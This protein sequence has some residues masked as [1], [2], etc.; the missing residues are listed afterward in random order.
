MAS[1]ELRPFGCGFFIR[2]FLLGRGPEGSP[3]IDPHKGACQEDI[4]YHYKLALHRAYAEDATAREN[5]DRIRAG[6]PVYTPEEHAERVDWHLRHIPYKLVKARYHSFQR[7]FRWLIQLGW[8][9][10]TGEEE[11][12]AMQEATEYHPDAHPRKL[13]RLTR[14]GIEATDEDWAHPQRLVYP[15]V[16]GVPIEDYF[17]EK[18]R[19]RKYRRRRKEERFLRPFTVGIFIREYL[20]GLGPED[21]RKIDPDEGDYPERI[22]YHYKEALRRA[23]ARD[24][25]A[26]ENEQRIRKGREPYT[27]EK[28]D[29]RLQWHLERIPYKLHRARYHS[30]FRYFHYLKQLDFVEATGREEVSYIQGNYPDAPPRTYYRLSAKGKLAPEYEWFRPQLTLYPELTPQYFSEKNRRRRHKATARS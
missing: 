2:E 21:S 28:Y 6:L 22:F 15:E 13:Y 16:M 5:E 23:Y 12:S 18:R 1:F 25:V 11:T 27:P 24:A 9:E 14:E 29:E 26:W 8:V 19:E 20:M 30:F 4:F 7:Y 10:P 17:R 3:K